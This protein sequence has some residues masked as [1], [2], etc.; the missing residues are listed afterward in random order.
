MADASIAR[1]LSDIRS[2]PVRDFNECADTLLHG[3]R[4]FHNNLLAGSA[5]SDLLWERAIELSI[6]PQG[7]TSANSSC[8]LLPTRDGYIAI[9]LARA[10]DWS[11]LP[12]W[13]EQ[14]AA[15][16]PQLAAKVADRATIPLLERGRL[17]GLAVA[18]PNEAHI[19]ECFDEL[20]DAS[21]TMSSVP[22]VVDLSALW[23]GPLCSHLLQQC[24]FRVIKVESIQ[25]PD[26]A[27]EGSPMHF[28]ALHKAKELRRFDFADAKELQTL[29]E[30][31]ASAD[32]VIEGS[33]PRA[34]RALGLD[35]ASLQN[36]TRTAVPS[37][38]W[39]SLT[40]YGRQL[41]Y[42][43]WVGFGDDVAIAAGACALTARQ[44]PG[45]IADAIADPLSGLMGALIIL[46]LRQQQMGGVVDFS[47][48]RAAKFCVNW[49][50]DS[51]GVLASASKYPKLRC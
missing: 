44:Q 3:L 13:L 8:R 30:L 46:H 27:R 41:P 35:R 21:G 28:N 38:L 22:L 12:A 47:L 40:A 16:W 49:I 39:L 51:G 32:V 33:R 6:V 19:P 7:Q 43:N 36:S 50:Q 4:A 31:L 24:G 1:C 42:G 14:P 34:L 9:N 45:F 15:D 10:E 2:I 26:G 23:A 5:G 48:F 37:Q 25:R 29:G 20:N 11:L 18:T 17:M